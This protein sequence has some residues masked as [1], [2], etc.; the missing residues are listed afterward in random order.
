MTFLQATTAA[1]ATPGV[2][3]FYLPSP[4]HATTTTITS[5]A[6]TFTPKGSL[7]I[8]NFRRRLERLRYRTGYWIFDRSLIATV[9]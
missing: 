5:E 4:R 8:A 2:K 7:S 6:L 3:C 1:S 9:S